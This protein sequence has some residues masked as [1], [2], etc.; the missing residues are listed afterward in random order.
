LSD[1]RKDAGRDHGQ[2]VLDRKVRTKKPKMFRVL[3]HNDDYSTMEFVVWLLERV[4]RKSSTEAHRLMLMI[5]HKGKGIAGVY[6]R[7]I[8]ETKVAQV[9][10]L[11]SEH[12]MPLMCTM[13]PDV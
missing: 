10:D 11:A 6:T 9:A 1:T 4:F 12:G 5:H 13:E 8:A 3:L 7:D 2:T